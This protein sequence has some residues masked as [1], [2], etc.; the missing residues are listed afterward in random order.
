MT[1]LGNFTVLYKKMGF[2]D[3]QYSEKL[4]QYASVEN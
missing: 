3:K 4:A 1:M 2:K